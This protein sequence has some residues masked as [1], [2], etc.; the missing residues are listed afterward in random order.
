MFVQYPGDG[1]FYR[2][3][4]DTCNTHTRRDSMAAQEGQVILSRVRLLKNL[5]LCF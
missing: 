1:L 3:L 4:C 5:P 2:V